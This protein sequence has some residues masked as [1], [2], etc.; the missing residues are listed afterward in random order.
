[1]ASIDTALN[2]IALLPKTTSADFDVVIKAVLQVFQGVEKLPFATEE[3]QTILRR[4]LRIMEAR[5]VGG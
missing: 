4:Y 3:L 5:Q 2:V 1:L